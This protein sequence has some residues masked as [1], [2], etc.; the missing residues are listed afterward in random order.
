LDLFG[1]DEDEQKT[2]ISKQPLAYRM[3]PASFDEFAGQQ[4]AVGEKGFL[5]EMLSG[6][7]ITSI[8]FWG[9]PGTG[10]TTLA[11]IIA[12]YIKAEFVTLSATSSGIKEVK[13][14]VERAKLS[15][16]AGKKTLLFIDEIHR[17]NK[18]QQDAFLPHV[19]NG[20]II[21]IGA[22]TENPS[23]EINSALLSRTRVITLKALEFN[24]IKKIALRAI[25]D[26]VRGLGKRK[27]K[28]SDEAIGIIEAVSNGDAR[29]T[30]NILEVIDALK[31][32][33]D[34]EITVDDVKRAADSKTSLYD[35]SGEEHYNII[36]ALHKSMRDSDPD[37]ALYWTMRM[38]EAGEDPLYV[39]RRV[40]RFASE[41]VGNA[42]PQA[43]MMANAAKDAYHF[44]GSPEGELAIAQAVLY[45]ASA[46]KS[47]ATYTAYLNAAQDVK[48][49]K[50]D[51]VPMNIRN[52][53]T[54]LMKE[55]GYGSGYKY[56]HDYEGNF[57]K[58][59]HLPDK[60]KD[61]VYYH[62][63]VNGLEK[64]IKERLDKWR[65]ES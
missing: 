60:I 15:L 56:A 38:F 42:D 24:D 49:T 11:M 4:Q 33:D 16:R 14:I 25:N 8:I 44:L 5:R 18:S 55:L 59:Q 58:Q 32:D 51:P 17:F 20:T 61:R 45:I 26:P 2:D 30:L 63:T 6:G 43:L 54:N 48:T 23:F 37:A 22:T 3:R 1:N 57:V 34:Y 50:D 52:A 9:P 35:K 31:T 39:I 28:I 19:E 46:P 64:S 13:E 21:L 27:I 7:K 47:N 53:P 40:I 10:K 62:P 41:D 36:S 65:K 29:S 12:K